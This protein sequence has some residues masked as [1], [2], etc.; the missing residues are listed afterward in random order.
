MA[1][2]QHDCPLEGSKERLAWNI[3][4]LREVNCSSAIRCVDWDE[5]NGSS[6]GKVSCPSAAQS[7]E[8]L[9]TQVAEVYLENI[10]ASTFTPGT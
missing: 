2:R 6:Y 7:V 4:F 8:G 5:F 10:Y 1:S 9:E 3:E